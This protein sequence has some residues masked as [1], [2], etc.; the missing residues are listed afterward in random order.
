MGRKHKRFAMDN[1]NWKE[2]DSLLSMLTR[3][4]RADADYE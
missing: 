1:G 2:L 4:L 3:P